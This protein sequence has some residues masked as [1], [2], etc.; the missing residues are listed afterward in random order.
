MFMTVNV[1]ISAYAR[2]EVRFV[3]RFILSRTNV[4]KSRSYFSTNIWYQFIF[5]EKQSLA[6]TESRLVLQRMNK[7][8]TI[9]RGAHSEFIQVI[10]VKYVFQTKMRKILEPSGY[11][12]FR[13]P[14]FTIFFA[15]GQGFFGHGQLGI[16]TI[17]VKINYDANP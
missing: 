14:H 6:R 7:L 9:I 10:P 16:H 11:I 17:F 3:T 13:S 12:S 1:S 4:S 5:L 15:L 8:F 2:H